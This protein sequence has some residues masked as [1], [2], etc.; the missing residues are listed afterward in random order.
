MPIIV[1]ALQQKGGVG[2]TTLVTSLFAHLVSGGYSAGILDLDPQGNASAWGVGQRVYNATPQ[3][4]GA[5]AFTMPRGEIAAAYSRGILSPELLNKHV[6]PCTKLGRGFVM[7]S[8]PYMVVHTFTEIAFDALPVDFVLVDTP[9]HLPVTA[10]RQIVQ[11]AHV[12]V[13]PV[14]PEAYSLQNIP[15]LVN[16][17]ADGGGQHLLDNDALR[18]VV[19]QRQ[20]CANHDAWEC[21]LRQHWDRWISPVVIARASSWGELA[22]SHSKWS[23]KNTVGKVAAQLWADIENT[24]SRRMAA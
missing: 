19:N 17:M 22:N 2:K 15:D 4:G 14:L 1:A 5:E 24:L 20:R 18:F 8:N 10:F 23:P 16:Q 7:P 11:H 21:V 12:V 6:L 9:P 13:S 3:H